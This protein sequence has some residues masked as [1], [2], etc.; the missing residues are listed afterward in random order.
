MAVG[1]FARGRFT[2][3]TEIRCKLFI[4]LPNG[5]SAFPDTENPKLQSP[6][7]LVFVR[8]VP[9][10]VLVFNRPGRAQMA[11]EV[12]FTERRGLHPEQSQPDR[13][14]CHDANG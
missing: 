14:P 11:M 6:P 12:L 4:Q 10:P 13:G 1:P 7:H 9:A 2:R 8:S 3:P 5:R